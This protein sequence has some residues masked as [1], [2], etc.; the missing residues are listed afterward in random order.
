MLCKILC[1]YIKAYHNTDYLTIYIYV[2]LIA[3]SQV[4]EEERKEIQNLKTNLF[5]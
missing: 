5:T 3:L 2:Y 4:C 1:D